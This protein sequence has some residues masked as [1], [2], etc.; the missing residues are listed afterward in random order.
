MNHFF[1]VDGMSIFLTEYEEYAKRSDV[2]KDEDYIL[3]NDVVLEAKS[4]DYQHGYMN[5]LS[6]QQRQYPL[7]RR[8]ILVNLIQ[9]GNDVQMKNDHPNNLKM[10]RSLLIKIPAR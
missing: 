5:H 8:D 7:R 10:E 1:T 4:D 6:A 3:T 9:K 2:Q